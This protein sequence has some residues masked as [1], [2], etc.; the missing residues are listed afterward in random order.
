MIHC[1]PPETMGRDQEFPVSIE[2]QLLGGLGSGERP[3][4]NVCTPGT[5][6]EMNGQLE[7]RHCLNSR[8]PTFHGDQWVT[9]EIVVDGGRR[10][11]HRVNGQDVLEYARPPYDPGDA[12][13]KR[14]M[15]DG[16]LVLER[17]YIALQAESHP[18]DFRRMEIQLLPDDGGPPR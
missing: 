4:A 7:T 10:I 8:S 16:G 13:A 18:I 2:V 5:H 3:T 11:V 15:A 9:V 14:L 1:Q 17:G 12:N 6:I